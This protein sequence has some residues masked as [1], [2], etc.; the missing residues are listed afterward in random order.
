M[1]P[2]TIYV[3]T[4]K[5]IGE[6]K[7][8]TNHLPG[9]VRRLLIL[10][11]GRSSAAEIAG[12]ISN[13]SE[14]KRREAF[15]KLLEEGFIR[16]SGVASD[17]PDEMEDDPMLTATAVERILADDDDADD[18]NDLSFDSASITEAE[19]EA[20][21]AAD[22]ASKKAKEDEERRRWEAADRARV[23]AEER[24]RAQREMERQEVE[25]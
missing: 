13:L 23:E 8:K 19:V 20:K 1:D 11:D 14:A 12:K 22:V 17:G 4:A 16:E 7:N 9:K 6:I 24:V 18:D 21:A 3:K 15:E 25:E 2:R 10:V 5:G